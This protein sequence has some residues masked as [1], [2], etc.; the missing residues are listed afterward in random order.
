MKIHHLNI[1]LLLLVII[2]QLS[3]NAIAINVSGVISANTTW[4]S[5]NNP[6]IVTSTITVN[7]GITL[8]I[9]SGVTIQFND[10]FGMNVLGTLSASGSTFTSSSSSPTPGKWAAINIG[11]ATNTGVVSLTSCQLSY[12]QSINIVKGTLTT[13]GTDLSNFLYYGIFIN[14]NSTNSAIANLTNGTFSNCGSCIYVNQNGSVTTSGTNLSNSINGFYFATNSIGVSNIIGGTISGMTTSAINDNNPTS[15]SFTNTTINGNCARGLLLNN[16]NL[17]MTGCTITSCLTPVE[18]GSPSIFNLSGTANNFLGNTNKYVFMNHS[19]LSSSIKLPNVNIPYYFPNGYTIYTGGRLELSDDNILK[20]NYSGINVYQGKLIANASVGKRIYFTSFKDDNL[21]G[22]ANG[23]GNA[24]APSQ[25]NWSGIDFPD[26]TIDSAC[27]LRRAT[28]KFADRGIEIT[29]ASP[30]L[31]SCNLSNNYHGVYVTDASY[32]VINACTF[33]SSGLTPIAQTF[34]AD[35]IFTGNIFSF[36]DNQYDAI[37]LIGSSIVANATLKIRS[38][39]STTNITYVM[40]GDITIPSGKSLTINKGIVIK[41]YNNYKITVLGALYANGTVD[42]NIVMTSVKDDNAGG[43]GDTNKDGTQTSPAKGDF[44]GIIFAPGSLNASLLNYCDI[45]FAFLSQNYSTYFAN[46]YLSSGSITMVNVSPTISNCKIS[47]GTNGIMCYQVSNPTLSNNTIV[48]CSATPIAISVSANPTFTNNTFTN[49]GYTGLGIIGE[50]IT[51]NGIIKKRNISGYTNITYVLL[52]NLTVANGTNIEVEAGVVIK[53][54]DYVGISVN[55]GFKISGNPLN[56]VTLTSVKD[57]NI[58]NPF[59]TNGDGNATTPTANNWYNINFNPTSDDSYSAIKSTDIKFAGYS[60][61]CAVKWDNAAAS[62]DDCLITNTNG[63]GL[64]FEG[65]SNPVIDSVRLVNGSS[66]PIGMSLTSDPTFS[67]ITFTANATKGINIIDANLSSNAILKKRSMAGISNIAYFINNLTINTGATLTIEAGVVIKS[68]NYSNNKSIAVN[69]A[70]IALGTPTEKI[71]F[72]SRKDDSNGG[73]YNNDGNASSPTKNDWIGITFGASSINSSLKNCIFR[74]S[75]GWSN[76]GVIHY[77]N[78]NNVTIDSSVIEQSYSPALSVL[79]SSTSVLKNTQLLNIDNVP[80]LM[81][82]FSNPVITNIS[83]NNVKEIGIGILPETYSQNAT[84]PIRNFAGYANITYIGRGTYTVNAGTVIN[85]P[86]GIV[87][88]GGNWVV[89]GKLMVNG[90]INAPVVFTSIAD[91]NYGNPLDSRQDGNTENPRN[92]AN[93]TVIQFEDISDDASVIRNAIFRYNNGSCIQLNSASPIIDSCTFQ[94]SRSGVYLTG[95]SQPILNNCKF[96]NLLWGYYSGN[97]YS[98]YPIQTSILSF[99]AS[100]L[101]NTISGS[102]TLKGIGIINETLSQDI[103][104]SKR[105]FGGINN[106]P[107][108]FEGFTIGSGATLTIAPGVVC[109]F[110]SGQLTVNKGLI[111]EGGSTADSSIVFTSIRDDFYAGDTNGDSNYTV[112]NGYNW[113]GISIENQALNNLCRFRNVIVKHA[114]YGISTISKSPS[115]SNSLFLKNYEAIRLT[116]ASNPIINNCDFMENTYF[117]VNNVNQSFTV[118]ARNCW[119]GN[120]TGPTISSNIGGTGDI[121]SNAVSYTPFRTTDAQ[122]PMMGDVSLNGKVQAFDAA[123]VLQKAVSLI[124]LNAIQNRV[125]D[126]SGT[127]GITAFDASLILQYVVDKI[128]V[129]PAEELYKSNPFEASAKLSI[130]NQN[131][132]EGQTFTVP[133]QVSNIKNAQALDLQL[134]YDQH[135]L[136]LVNVSA[137]NFTNGLNIQQNIDAVSGIIY[138][139]VAATDVFKTTNGDWAILTFKVKSN[140]NSNVKTAIQVVK[141]LAN[142]S[143]MSLNIENG[144]VQINNSTGIND[145]SD[146]AFKE[147]YPNPFSDYINFPFL[148][149]NTDNKLTIQVYSIV[150]KMVFEQS[151]ENIAIGANS[152]IWDGKNNNGEKLDVGTYLVYFKSNT[153]NWVEKINLVK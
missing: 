147:P 17:G 93:G 103:T 96:D 70:I 67:N 72:T 108:I 127:G 130:P 95:V 69:G 107:Y 36:Q 152:L 117:G 43:P 52:D 62:M 57:D 132:I 6:Y 77:D 106:I 81:A 94:T 84:I 31:D 40:L 110:I 44:G 105:N 24:T 100:I 99:P 148:F 73:D 60:N 71:I 144:L 64:R 134:K 59:D 136:E 7:P 8:T 76:Q 98:G 11:D 119:W 48:N 83:L 42:S 2:F 74:Y 125:A 112:Q 68:F 26:A 53:I 32:P 104:L 56:R 150:G 49:S 133:I 80:V 23:D 135:L 20:F 30:T 101:N 111:A 14:G 1:K 82:M 27:I 128:S 123:Q 143:S 9:Q 118:D 91:D 55:G 34:D 149:S 92:F 122:N 29:N 16:A 4:T 120:N 116:G 124:T 90:T 54:L 5:A 22:D 129:F 75:G 50:V 109:K 140:K 86:A 35:P 79:G 47:N 113:S 137:S 3:F 46:Q 126:V 85:I 88:K 63:F 121:I 51:A 131:V 141:F 145:L 38:V 25:N 21:G 78:A 89:N 151:F 12:A 33:G 13:N 58:G 87:F 19:S 102:Y 41:S 28:I 10:N 65:N 37:G 142:E 115:I 153:T 61:S 97:F 18:Y 146:I 138:L 15:K 66:D 45:R 139:S 114:Y 39:T